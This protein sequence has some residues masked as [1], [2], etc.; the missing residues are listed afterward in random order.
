MNL[1][2]MSVPTQLQK[3]ESF[4]SKNSLGQKDNIQRFLGHLPQRSQAPHLC[5]S[6]R[7]G[8][9]Q[10]MADH[11]GHRCGKVVSH[12]E[13]TCQDVPP[14]QWSMFTEVSPVTC[15]TSPTISFP[16]SLTRSFVCCFVYWMYQTCNRNSSSKTPHFLLLF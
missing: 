16:L 1:P 14:W 9:H 15:S 6:E 13:H 12:R 10:G 3:A 5:S 11:Y 8:C 7:R 4:P 2:Y